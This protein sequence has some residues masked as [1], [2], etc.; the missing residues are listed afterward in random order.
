M[1]HWYLL[2]ALSALWLAFEIWLVLRDRAQGKGKGDRDR[3]S[4]YVNFLSLAVGITAA[5]VIGGTRWFLPWKWTSI[6][7][8]IGFAVMLVG[9]GLRIWAIVV[10]GKSFRT[11]VETHESQGVV[12][13]GPYALI[14]HPSYS[15]LVAVSVG[16]GI[17]V[18]NWFSLI[19]AVLIPL[20]ALLYRIHV[21]EA[22]LESSLGSQYTDYQKRTRKLIPWI[23]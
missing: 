19:V 1:S 17:A 23:W 12:T 11:T 6:A 4:F 2:W 16:Y 20:V 18:Q 7:Y 3:G 13:S 21:E 9:L 10:L 14:R 15:G 8:W 22:V 5:G